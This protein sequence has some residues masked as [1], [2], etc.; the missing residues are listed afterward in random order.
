MTND[1]WDTHTFWDTD[2]T[3]IIFYW[4]SDEFNIYVQR[5]TISG[6]PLSSAIKIN[7]ING[8]VC[9]SSVSRDD[10]RLIVV[11]TN[12]DY[13]QI[14]AQRIDNNLSFVGNNFIIS[15]GSYYMIY[16][17]QSAM[18]NGIVYTV[19]NDYPYE[20]YLNIFDYDDPPV[21]IDERHETLPQDFILFQNYPNPFNSST[22][23]NFK[24]NE[25]LEIKIVIYDLLGNQVNLITDQQYKPGFY[26]I[27]WNGKNDKGIQ[28]PSGIYFVKAFLPYK[29]CTNKMVLIK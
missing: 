2:S 12:R 14:Y 26:T 16:R 1:V 9:A 7:K 17:L 25:T 5:F 11:W 3:L 24:I 10:E 6:K 27:Q 19:F 28:M 20:I 23:I 13:K 29:K 8:D 4:A 21:G 15:S 22:S 18:K